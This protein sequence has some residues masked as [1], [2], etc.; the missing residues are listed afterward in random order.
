M[1]VSVS[2]NETERYSI[3]RK[4][5][6]RLGTKDDVHR[7]LHD[8]EDNAMSSRLGSCEGSQLTKQPTIDDRP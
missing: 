1:T 2:P 7:A 5:V 8:E 6:K 4:V 3:L